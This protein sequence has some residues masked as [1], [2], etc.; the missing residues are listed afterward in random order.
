MWKKS[1]PDCITRIWAAASQQVASR[2]IHCM[3]S[4]GQSACASAPSEL[5]FAGR[6]HKTLNIISYIK[7]QKIR[8]M[9]MGVRYSH[10][11]EDIF[12]MMW[13]VW[14][15]TLVLMQ[16]QSNLNISN[17]DGSVIMANSN[18]L[19]SADEILW[20][21]QENKYLGNFSYFIMKLYDL[22]THYN[23][24]IEAILMN[25]LNIQLLCRKLQR[26]P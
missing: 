22:Y 18:S 15:K 13:P 12:R 19:W 16:I 2:Y 17:T 14:H 11:F 9:I 6:S 10:C 26:F 24:I 23:R 3:D 1:W 20:I 21:A 5:G 4:E 7:E 25:K 8:K